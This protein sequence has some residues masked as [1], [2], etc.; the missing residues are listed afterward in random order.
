MKGQDLRRKRVSA[1]IPGT[2]VCMQAKMDRAKLSHIERDLVRISAA[3][4]ARLDQILDQLIKAKRK[5]ATAAKQ[6]GWPVAA[7]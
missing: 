1:G 3:E 5:M 7:L 6:C 4:L 2:I